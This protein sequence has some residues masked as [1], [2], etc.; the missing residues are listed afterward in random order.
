MRR[1]LAGFARDA[2]AQACFF[3]A[4]GIRVYAELLRAVVRLVERDPAVA[5]VLE[6]AWRARDFSVA[7]ER[8]LL[9]L[10]SLR[11]DALADAAHPL[12]RALAISPFTADVHDEAIKDSLAPGRPALARLVHGFVQ[13]NEVTRAIAWRLPLAPWKGA[14][15]VALVDI[16]CSAA[17]NLVADRM[18]LAWTDAAG[19]P[20][21]LV[22]TECVR[23]RIGLDRAPIDAR[24]E[25]ARAWLRACLWPGQ[26]ARH[27]RLDRALD[28]AARA[29]DAGEIELRRVDAADVPRELSRIAEGAGRVLAYQT[30]FSSYLPAP[31]RAVY[32]ERMTAFV[33][34]NPERS[35]WAELE[36]APRG[37][38][39]PAEVR[40]HT[41]AGMRVLGA[42]DYHPTN[43]VAPDG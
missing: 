35:M 36:G 24:D 4:S 15:D 13:T 8:P 21:A 27:A 16:G 2:E 41:S 5:G 42:C 17:L 10:A 18:E 1:G 37:R 31:E 33:R 7:Y 9:L 22:A 23:R 38:P 40:L 20:I 28:L 26:V 43:L 29:L 32:E 25:G 34:A 30:I 14:R 11:A 19:A 39:G 6:D 3:E 12:A